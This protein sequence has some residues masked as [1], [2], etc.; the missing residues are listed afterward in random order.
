MSPYALWLKQ[1]LFTAFVRK[2]I[3]T[4]NWFATKCIYIK[5]ERRRKGHS[6]ARVVDV[7][8]FDSDNPSSDPAWPDWAILK[9]V[10]KYL[11]TFGYI[12]KS[13]TFKQKSPRQLY[14]ATVVKIGCFLFQQLV[15]RFIPLITTVFGFPPSTFCW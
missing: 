6:E 3:E 12:L 15:T 5:V 13:V 7:L 1:K 2:K 9:R 4:Q 11:A 10:T 8:A 14:D